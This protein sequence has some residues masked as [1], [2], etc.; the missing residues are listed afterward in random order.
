MAG[1]LFYAAGLFGMAHAPTP[2]TVFAL[3]RAC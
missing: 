2:L 3:T 1:A